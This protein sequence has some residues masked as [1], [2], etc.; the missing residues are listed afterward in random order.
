MEIPTAQGSKLRAESN[1]LLEQNWGETYK[2]SKTDT[3]N[4]KGDFDL[5]KFPDHKT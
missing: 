5:V 3:K 2:H 4:S 1:D